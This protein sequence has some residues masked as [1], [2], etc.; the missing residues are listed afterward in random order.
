MSNF[1]NDASSI[2]AVQREEFHLSGAF[3]RRCPRFDD[4]Q[5]VLIDHGGLSG[6][7]SKSS[8]PRLGPCCACAAF[9]VRAAARAV[10]AKRTLTYTSRLLAV[11]TEA[12]RSREQYRLKSQLG[13]LNG[14]EPAVKRARCTMHVTQSQT[15]LTRFSFVFR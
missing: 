1:F 4:A 8:R 7:I 12:R 9:S 14:A 15:S 3:N 11:I 6:Q 13:S 5:S 10:L 2:E